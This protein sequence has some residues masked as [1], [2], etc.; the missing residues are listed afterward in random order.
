MLREEVRYQAG[1][2]LSNLKEY[3]YHISQ[4][5]SKTLRNRGF[6]GTKVRGDGWKRGCLLEGQGL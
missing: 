4:V 1:S 2:I 6:D 5:P 3:S